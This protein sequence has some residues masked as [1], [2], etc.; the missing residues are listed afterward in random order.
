MPAFDKLVIVTQKTALEELLERYNT[1]DQARFY[2][3]H[4][5][6][7]FDG[8]QAAHDT[9]VAAVAALKQALPKAARHQFVDRGYLPNFLFGPGDLVVTLGRDGLVVNTAKYLAEQPLLGL[10]PDPARIDGILLPFGVG[11]AERLLPAVLDGSFVSN[12]VTMA[13]AALNTRQ[14][15]YAVNDFF[16]GQRTHTSARY[17]I[18]HLDRDEDQSSSGIIV[19]TGAGSTGWFRSVLAGAAGVAEGFHTPARSLKEMRDQFRFPWDAG[20]LRY[21]VREPFTSKTS[22]AT[23]VFGRLA[24]GEEL[25]VTSQMPRNG[26]VFSDGVEADGLEFVSGSVLRIGVADRSLRLITRV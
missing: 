8:Y 10:N 12:N 22:G 16:I 21:C 6:V 3:E 18:Q 13:H 9:Y 23:I 26:I 5:G 15:L 20:E 4:M 24:R 19:S 2:L 17:R 11:Q 14:S 1:R 25:I 7:P